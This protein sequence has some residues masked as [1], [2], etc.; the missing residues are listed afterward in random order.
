[1]KTGVP[2][3]LYHMISDRPGN[4]QA[5]SPDLFAQQMGYLFQSGF[6]PIS[7]YQLYNS[8]TGKCLLPYRPVIITFDDGYQCQ[9]TNALPILKRYRFTATFFIIANRPEYSVENYMTWEQ[10]RYIKYSGWSVESHTVTHPHLN[11]LSLDDQTKEIWLSKVQL[12]R[13]LG[14][15]VCFFAYPYGEYNAMTI[16][17]VKN[18]GY[19]GAFIGRIGKIVPGEELFQLKRSFVDGTKGMEEFKTILR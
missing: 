19:L 10:L 1:M 9:F 14:T 17:I 6:N 12:E 4:P 15:P 11:A 8:L 18:C 3:L 16:N 7:P 2:V 5:V 13:N